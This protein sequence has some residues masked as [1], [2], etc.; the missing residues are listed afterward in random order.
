MELPLIQN[1]IRRVSIFRPPFTDKRRGTPSTAEVK[2]TPTDKVDGNP[3]IDY[4]RA[5]EE[6]FHHVE[7]FEKAAINVAHNLLHDEV[8]TLF[9][10]HVIHDSS[11]SENVEKISST[12][13]SRSGKKEV[14]QVQ[15]STKKEV[16]KKEDPAPVVYTPSNSLWYCE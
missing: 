13:R 11:T 6:I 8:E 16:S 9:G 14:Q 12:R 7:D 4:E 3:L 10:D 2:A 1:F 5:E 15:V